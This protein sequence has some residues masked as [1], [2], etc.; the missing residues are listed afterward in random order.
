MVMEAVRDGQLVR[1][2]Q[3]A[4]CGARHPRIEGHHDDYDEPLA[5][6]WLCKPCHAQRHDALNPRY[7]DARVRVRLAREANPWIS[8]AAIARSLNLT[9]ERVSRLL[10]EIGLGEPAGVI[11]IYDSALWEQAQSYALELS[12]QE[13][14]QV[15]TSE[16]MRRILERA[17][18]RREQQR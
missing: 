8:K 17:L 18:K 7:R 11:P 2:L 4:A 13:G 3:C 14:K 12:Q 15:S 16:A 6:E 9:L 10:D 1:P 5:V